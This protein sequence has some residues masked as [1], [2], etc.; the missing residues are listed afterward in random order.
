MRRVPGEPG[1]NTTHGFEIVDHTETAAEGYT[2]ESTL[3]IEGIAFPRALEDRAIRAA[4][5]GD[6]VQ[7]PLPFLDHLL[8]RLRG[9]HPEW[10]PAARIA[11]AFRAGVAARRRLDGIFCEAS[12]LSFRNCYYVCLRAARG[13]PGFWTS[14]YA[15]YLSRRRGPTACAQIPAFLVG[16]RKG[17][18]QRV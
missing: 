3:S 18:P 9:H 17:W 8:P 7:L 2:E 12:S 15:A 11:R 10:S 16:A 5:I 4:T 14:D 6:L 1:S 13:E